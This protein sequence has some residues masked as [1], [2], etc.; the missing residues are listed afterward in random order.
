MVFRKII[1]LCVMRLR[2]SFEGFYKD[3]GDDG[4][5]T[6]DRIDND[7]GYYKENCRWASKA[8]QAR[9]KRIQGAL[10]VNGIRVSGSGKYEAG[11]NVFGKK[12][13]LGTFSGFFDACCARKS[14]EITY[15]G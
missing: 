4:G 6:I 13:H 3:M 7:K 2:R 12:I 5:L 1:S 11:I 10:G 15:W 8:I 9:N 14:A